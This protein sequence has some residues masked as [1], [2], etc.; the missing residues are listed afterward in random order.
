MISATASASQ[1]NVRTGDVVFQAKGFPTFIT[2][3][4]ETKNLDGT[5][6]V[7]GGK[8]MGSFKV[9]MTSLKTGMDLRDDHMINKYL[10]AKKFPQATLT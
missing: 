3:K 8:A 9:A 7:E 2:I 10:E 1:Y 4:G 6:K 5:L